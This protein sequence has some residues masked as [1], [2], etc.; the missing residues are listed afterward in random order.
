[1]SWKVQTGKG[2]AFVL[3]DPDVLRTDD[4]A[5][6]FKTVYYAEGYSPV[7]SYGAKRFKSRALAHLKARELTKQ[8]RAS[9]AMRRMAKETEDASDTGQA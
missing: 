2:G 5:S 8:E 3:V 9:K 6:K 1:M 4:P 7:T